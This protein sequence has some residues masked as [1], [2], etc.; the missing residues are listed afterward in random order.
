MRKGVCLPV[1]Q[2]LVRYLAHM[3]AGR[4]VLWCYF[5][6]YLA[7]TTWY[8]DPSWRVWLTAAGISLIIGAALLINTTRSG[9]RPVRLERWPAVRLFL[10]PFCVSSF[11]ALVK[12]H[13]F[14][15][16]FSPKPGELIIGAA[17]CA[18]FAAAVA[19]AKAANRNH[20]DTEGHSIA[21]ITRNTRTHG[22]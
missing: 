5:I 21:R 7:V 14:W 13:G 18:G 20:G 19:L 15:L 1:F 12:G 9:T 2:R 10:F 17:L 11:S 16:V 3:S 22:E 8:F 4:L 6:W